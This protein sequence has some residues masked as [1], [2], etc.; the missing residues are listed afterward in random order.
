M[1][2]RVDVVLKVLQEA[3]ASSTPI[4][5]IEL[6]WEKVVLETKSHSQGGTSTGSA[7]QSETRQVMVPNIK[8]EYRKYS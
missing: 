3:K 6:T 5:S 2:D 1:E 7:T 8:I 4:S